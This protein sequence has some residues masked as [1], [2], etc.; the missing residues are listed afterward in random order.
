MNCSVPGRSIIIILH[1][2]PSQ[3]Q[4]MKIQ[5]RNVRSQELRWRYVGA[6]VGFIIHL[7]YFDSGLPCF[8]YSYFC[9]SFAIL[10]IVRKVRKSLGTWVPGWRTERRITFLNI[11][12]LSSLRQEGREQWWKGLRSYCGE[13]VKFWMYRFSDIFISL[14]LWCLQ[15]EPLMDPAGGF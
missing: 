2:L 7:C 4:F 6:L 15:G 9:L 8:T 5:F 1:G 11:L 13:R 14:C 10:G 3:K 12:T